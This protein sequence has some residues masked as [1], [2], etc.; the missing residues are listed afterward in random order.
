M[1]GSQP[2]TQAGREGGVGGVFLPGV[3][4]LHFPFSFSLGKVVCAALEGEVSGARDV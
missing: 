1:S 3:P 2:L 4:F